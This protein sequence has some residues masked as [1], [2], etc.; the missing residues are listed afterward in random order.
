VRA[1]GIYVPQ[2]IKDQRAPPPEEAPPPLIALAAPDVLAALGDFRP[3]IGAWAEYSI[4]VHKRE[5]GRVLVSVLPP[6]MPDG[7]YWLELDSTSEGTAPSALRLLAHGNPVDAESFDRAI[8]YVAGQN[9]FEIPL[10][11]LVSKSAK[12]PPAPSG[13]DI[14]SMHAGKVTVRAGTFNAERIRVAKGKDA[15]VVWRSSEVPLFGLVKSESADKT[16]ELV[17]TGHS[18]AHTLI[19]VPILDEAIPPDARAQPPGD[20]QGNGSDSK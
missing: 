19:S 4:S 13:A 16:T 18:G 17:Q 15:T 11:M 14:S 2:S 1:S 3:E 12:P 10:Q 9:T 6:P 5:I 20:A 7:R 8:V